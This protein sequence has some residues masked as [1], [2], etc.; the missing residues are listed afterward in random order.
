MKDLTGNRYG[1][2]VV[3]GFSHVHKRKRYFWHCRCDCGQT[4]TVNGDNLTRGATRSCRCLEASSKIGR[5][6]THGQR[7]SPEYNCWAAMKGRCCNPNNDAYPDYGGRGVLVCDRWLISF[8]NFLLDMGPRP[9]NRHSLDRFPDP[10]GNYEPGNCRWAT[11]K[12]QNRNKRVH[13]ILEF[14]GQRKMLAEWADTIGISPSAL[15]NRL[16]RWSLDRALGTPMIVQH[17]NSAKTYCDNG[18]EY[19]PQN[20]YI[21]KGKRAGERKCRECERRRMRRLTASRRQ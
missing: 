20:T 9:S 12:Q 21:R 6:R 5:R 16:K 4:A 15:E 13:R 2:L 11:Q 17:P 14:N 10:F 19:T 18:H 1:L 3:T 7:Q 8:E